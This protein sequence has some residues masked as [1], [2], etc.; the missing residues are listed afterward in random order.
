[1]FSCVIKNLVNIYLTMITKEG[2]NVPPSGG[3]K[4]SKTDR[5]RTSNSGDMSTALSTPMR[6]HRQWL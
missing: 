1:M 4:V 2:K 5:V 6:M 3:V